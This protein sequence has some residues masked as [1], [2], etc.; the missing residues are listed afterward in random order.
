MYEV[1][2]DA[3]SDINGVDIVDIAETE[4]LEYIK[5]N[6]SKIKRIDKQIY[7]PVKKTPFTINIADPSN[8]YDLDS[9]DR[10]IIIEFSNYISIPHMYGSNPISPTDIRIAAE[11]W[12]SAPVFYSSTK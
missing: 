11:F 3:E 5:L 9:M 12:K 4:I 2:I 1:L 10:D 8:T 6:K 7:K